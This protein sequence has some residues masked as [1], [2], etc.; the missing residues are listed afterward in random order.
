MPIVRNTWIVPDDQKNITAPAKFNTEMVNMGEKIYMT[1]CKSCHGD[2]GH[3]N[4]VQLNP[5][6]K[7]LATVAAQTD[8]SFYYKIKEGRVLMPTF[9]STLSVSD[10]W[11]VIAYIRSFHKDYVQPEI[12]ESVIFNGSAVLLTLE[13]LQESKQFKVVAMSTEDKNPEPTEGIE[14]SVFA[15][16]YFGNLKLDDDKLTNSDGVALF[17][18]PKNLPADAEG[19]LNIIAKVTDP[20]KYGEAIAK[21]EIKAGVPTNKPS[22]TED[23]AMWNVV[24][25]APWWITFTYPLSVLAVLATLF[26]IFLLLKK[27]YVLGKKESDT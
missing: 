18:L 9:K 10:K 26:Y 25:K 24:S 16:R 5:L 1:N 21:A 12:K 4:M 8:G 20:D 11:N 22:L 13:Y 7:D 6:P 3:N 17:S 15:K 14:V 23:R 27:V 19:N 2:I